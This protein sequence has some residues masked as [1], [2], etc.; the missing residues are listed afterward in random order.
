[1]AVTVDE[2]GRTQIKDIYTVSAPVSGHL[3][4]P[5]IEA[6]DAVEAN[7]T[8]LA[9]IEAS[10][11]PFLDART[12]SELDA[13]LMAAHAAVTAA[14][15]ELARA[16]S[17]LTFAEDDLQRARRLARTGTIPARRLD[18]TEHRTEAART[19]ATAAEAAVEMR[20]RERDAVL[21]RLGRGATAADPAGECCVT[22]KSPA[23]GRV[24]GLLAD[25]ERDIAAGT[26]ILQIGDPA[27]LEIVVE[28]L[29]SDAVQIVGGAAVSIEDWGGEIPLSGTV[30]RIE[31][32][33]FTKVSALGIEEQR[34]RVLVA[35]D[36]PPA[37]RP[38]LGHDYRVFTRI[39]AWS[40]E[41]VLRVPVGALFRSGTDWAV[42]RIETGIARVARIEIGHRNG[43]LA[44]VIA[45]LAP[46]DRVILHP[47]DLVA[48]GV[49]VLKRVIE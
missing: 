3:R 14:E 33:G 36:S 39:A 43:E 44:E 23:N 18:E 19:T 1:M 26:P 45:G 35:L 10:V 37:D 27:N 17:E 47:S 34:V 42:Y 29:S 4:R 7:R 22:I 32:S 25:S 24:L 46:G 38:R 8:E 49:R 15:A 12:K 41:G 5:S 6:G 21:A 28:L 40:S 13:N 11:P 31:P 30:D 9:I 2:E 16:R 48:D 20:K